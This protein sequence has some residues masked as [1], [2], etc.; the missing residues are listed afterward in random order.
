M[1]GCMYTQI[2]STLDAKRL[3]KLDLS[4]CY[5]L[6]D[7]SVQQAVANNQKLETL[8]LKGCIGITADLL[9]HFPHSRLK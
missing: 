6:T 3:R 1:A 5:H 2:L 8:L 4:G 9:V 7:A